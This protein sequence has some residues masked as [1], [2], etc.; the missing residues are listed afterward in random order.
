MPARPTPSIPPTD[1]TI[2]I[3]PPKLDRAR[4]ARTRTRPALV[5]GR[6]AVVDRGRRAAARASFSRMRSP[7]ARATSV[8]SASSD[9]STSCTFLP[10]PDRAGPHRR[11]R[12][13][14]TGRSSSIV[15]RAT[16]VGGPGSW[17]SIARASSAAGAPPCCAFGSHGPRA[18]S[19][20]DEAR[21]RRAAKIA[22]R[23]VDIRQPIVGAARRAD[24]QWRAGRAGPTCPVPWSRRCST[25]RVAL[26]T[27]GGSGQGR[28]ASVLFAEHGARIVVADINDDGAGETIALV[29]AAGSSGDRGARRHL[30]PR[31]L[32]R[33]GR[34]P[35]SAHFGRLDILYNNAAVQM[36]GPARRHDRGRL[37][38][39]D[40]DEPRRGVLGVPGRAPAPGRERATRSIIS[41]ASVLGLIGSEGYAAYGAAKAGLVALDAPDRD[42]VRA[43]RCAPT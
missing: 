21:R 23:A 34:R 30:A 20:G 12:P 14:G 29:D 42:R 22:R 24:A 25:G 10:G 31:R 37:G 18:S 39:H 40:R 38:P 41:T 3:A 17:R 28:A 9:A 27:G 36:S 33:D 15:S 8:P 32:R 13:S 43:R 6:E 35:R 2:S 4:P 7:V 16:C 11:S 1:G 26:I 5:P 19:V